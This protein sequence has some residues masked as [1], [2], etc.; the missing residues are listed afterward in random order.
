MCLFRMS[1]GV[2]ARHVLSVIWFDRGSFVCVRESDR[3]QGSCPDST[4]KTGLFCSALLP[5]GAS[6]SKHPRNCDRMRAAV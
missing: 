5:F 3:S 4:K 6:S 1:R 2:T